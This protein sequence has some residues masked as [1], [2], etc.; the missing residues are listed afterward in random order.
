MALV[1]KDGTVLT[2][3]K[4]IRVRNVTGTV[5]KTKGKSARLTAPTVDGYQFMFW[6]T[7]Y[8]TGWIASMYAQE[9]QNQSTNFWVAA[10]NGNDS[11]ASGTFGAIAVYC[12]AGF[13]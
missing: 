12:P 2:D 9:P 3:L 10:I 7:C 1:K 13:D 11:T 6:A 5:V 8:T 4:P